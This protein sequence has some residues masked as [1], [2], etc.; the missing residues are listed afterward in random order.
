MKLLTGM[1]LGYLVLNTSIALAIAPAAAHFQICF[2]PDPNN[3]AYWPTNLVPQGSTA[4]P[5]CITQTY[6]MRAADTSP[7]V[8]DLYYAVQNLVTHV[9]PRAGLP[10]P[11]LKVSMQF[12]TTGGNC[13]AT[14]AN[15]MSIDKIAD[16]H[17][18]VPAT[19]QL[20]TTGNADAARNGAFNPYHSD[21][22]MNCSTKDVETNFWLDPAPWNRNNS[23]AAEPSRAD[24]GRADF[25]GMQMHELLHGLGFES[26]RT[27]ATGKY[28]DNNPPT[29]FDTFLKQYPEYYPSGNEANGQS[30]TDHFST[31]NTNQTFFEGP[32]VTAYLQSI[33]NSK[34][35]ELAGAP[36]ASVAA[37]EQVS[38]Q[39]FSHIGIIKENLGSEADS[40]DNDCNS[41]AYRKG[42]YKIFGNDLMTMCYEPIFSKNYGI[43]NNRMNVSPLDYAIIEDLGYTVYKAK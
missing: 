41:V 5:Y 38:T 19:L 34:I 26:N 25:T 8:N 29:K 17:Y 21:I 42:A 15:S 31:N 14:A 27:P 20:F 33:P 39:N 43:R 28:Y 6:N 40:F 12:D 22:L 7:F 11:T 18:E 35:K 1:I 3:H 4:K 2:N 37:S 23:S 13:A 16:L 24:S 30:F 32:H 36:I 10:T 9:R